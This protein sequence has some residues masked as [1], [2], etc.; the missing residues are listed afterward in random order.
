MRHSVITLTMDTYGHLFPGQEADTVARLPNLLSNP[1]PEVMS[2]D[3]NR[4][5]NGTTAPGRS[6]CAARRG[7]EPAK[8]GEA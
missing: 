6:A 5:S 4:R 7:R 2:G 3:R 1:L 8:D